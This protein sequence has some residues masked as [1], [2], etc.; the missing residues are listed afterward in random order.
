MCGSG[1]PGVRCRPYIIR[2][3]RTSGFRRAPQVQPSHGATIF[4]AE[5]VVLFE[6]FPI[7]APDSALGKSTESAFF[8]NEEKV[9][10]FSPIIC[11]IDFLCLLLQSKTVDSADVAQLARAADL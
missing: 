7:F 3:G 2:Y 10:I 9:E 11:A 5:T 4:F 1:R 8:E 6:N